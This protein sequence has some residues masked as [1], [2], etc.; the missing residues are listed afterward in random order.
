[1]LEHVI[2]LV[3]ATI[4][5]K[6][7]KRIK[8]V[9]ENKLTNMLF[10]GMVLTLSGCAGLGDLFAPEKIPTIA[11]AHIGHAITSWRTTPDKKGLFQVAE[12]EANI[13]YAH[14][15]YAVQKLDDLSLIKLHTGHAMHAVD[16]NS[17]KKG[18]GLGFGLKRDVSE[19][20]DH[21][22]YA[23]DSDDASEHVRSFAKQFAASA[24]AVLQRCDLILA[25]GKDIRQTSSTQEAAALAEEVLKISRAILEGMD[26]DGNGVVPSSPDEYGLKQLRA[27]ITDMTNREVPSYQPVSRRYLLGLVRLANGKWAYRL[28]EEEDDFSDEGGY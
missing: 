21:I 9:I 17:L 14:A 18:P 23:A 24:A 20:V 12:Q 15:G 25:L 10:L 26:S 3:V 16:P 5:N 1:L 13:A 2:L 8:Q 19:S 28:E 6:F 11:H 27:Q 7:N 22:S 4:K